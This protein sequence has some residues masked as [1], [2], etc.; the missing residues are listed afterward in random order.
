L[1]QK[2]EELFWLVPRIT[3]DGL[4]RRQ[5]VSGHFAVWSRGRRKEIVASIGINPRGATREQV[6]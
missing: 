2:S 1:V 4:S 6:G 5:R 3:G